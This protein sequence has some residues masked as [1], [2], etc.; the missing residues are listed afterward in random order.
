M[1]EAAAQVQGQ[2]T[3]QPAQAPGQAIHE[4]TATIERLTQ[5]VNE[6]K[7]NDPDVGTDMEQP[8]EAPET[9]DAPETPD[10]PETTEAKTDQPEIEFDEETPVFEVEYKTDTG[11]EAK[12]LSL[13]EMRDGYLRMQD[14]HRNIQKVKAQEAQLQEQIRTASITAAKE[15]SEKLEAQKKSISQLSGVKTLPEIEA[16]SREDPAAAQQEFLKMISVNQAMERI[17]AEQRQAN[18]KLQADQRAALSEAIAKSRQTLQSDIDG[19][20][21]EVY[22]TVISD[23]AGRYGFDGKDVAQVIDARLIKVFHDAYKYG[24]LQKAKPQVSKKV[25][26]IPKV[27]KPG[28]AE[29]PNPAKEAADQSYE[30]LQKTGKGEDFVRWY[31]NKNKKG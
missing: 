24:Q 9:T 21:D 4:E 1:A 17:E 7:D 19:W 12:K 18:E 27:I 23:I 14:Y 15:Y 20:N 16:M 8:A 29:K 10:K 13:K 22:N 28:S 26:A 11:K 2:A 5:W 6:N 31:L 30:R 25:V 3:S